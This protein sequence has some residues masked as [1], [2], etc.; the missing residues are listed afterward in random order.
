MRI[1]IQKHPPFCWYLRVHSTT[2]MPD[3]L[4]RSG[5][6]PD[7]SGDAAALSTFV[8]LF[9]MEKEPLDFLDERNLPSVLEPLRLLQL[10]LYPQTKSANGYT[11]VNNVDQ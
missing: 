10:A 11:K 8:G 7:T 2:G 4:K 6:L 5:Y 1:N 9:M 3:A